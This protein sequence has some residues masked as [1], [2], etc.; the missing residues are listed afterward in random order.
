MACWVVP[1][2]RRF[3]SARGIRTSRP[4]LMAWILLAFPAAEGGRVEPQPTHCLPNTQ[5][6]SLLACHH[7]VESQS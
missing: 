6:R 2:R 3:T 4:T 1:R 5:Q 7:S